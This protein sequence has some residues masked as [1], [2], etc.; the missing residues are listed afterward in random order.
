VGLLEV[1]AE[2]VVEVEVGG[3]ASVVGEVVN[4]PPSSSSSLTERLVILLLLLPLVHQL[5]SP[6]FL[7]NED[8]SPSSRSLMMKEEVEEVE[9]EDEEDELG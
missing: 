6:P 8:Q 5:N 4:P 9:D 1:V 7:W 3:I 2:V